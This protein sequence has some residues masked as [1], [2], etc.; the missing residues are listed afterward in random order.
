[1]LVANCRNLSKENKTKTK[2]K[3]RKC[4]RIR[5]MRERKFTA[6]WRPTAARVS[7]SV[8][9][10]QNCTASPTKDTARHQ[11]Q[12]AVI[13]PLDKCQNINT[14]ILELRENNTACQKK[15]KQ[16]TFA[17]PSSVNVGVSLPVEQRRVSGEYDTTPDVL[18]LVDTHTTV[19]RCHTQTPLTYVRIEKVVED[20][21]PQRNSNNNIMIYVKYNHVQNVQYA[22]VNIS[23]ALYFVLVVKRRY[24]ERVQARFPPDARTYGA[25][26]FMKT[27]PHSKSCGTRSPPGN[28]AVTVETDTA[29]SG[30]HGEGPLQVSVCV[31][32]H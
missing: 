25:T 28:L 22:E 29:S 30:T 20:R 2:E 3:S 12:H 17:C 18:T 32:H 10:V 23:V 11:E 6:A 9:P 21:S 15:P 16:I 14:L 24:H 7:R 19:T 27:T 8:W 5:N 4:E 26:L 1:M 31:Y 13:H